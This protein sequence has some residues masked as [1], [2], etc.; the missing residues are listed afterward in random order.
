V[1]LPP[2]RVL[3][4]CLVSGICSG[5][6]GFV[7]PNS[8]ILAFFLPGIFYGL[9]FLIWLPSGKKSRLLTQ[10]T[11]VLASGAICYAAIRLAISAHNSW[12]EWFGFFSA[13]Y[14]GAALLH[15]L[16]GF[17]GQ[18]KLSLE[19]NLLAAFSG[20]LLGLAFLFQVHPK[21]DLNEAISLSLQFALWQVGMGIVLY[22][23]ALEETAT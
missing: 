23:Q 12:P 6:V 22:H 8:G 4:L 3:L 5:L 19:K 21:S 11:L 16:L 7:L 18:L 20:A 14:F 15:L 9:L 17:F 1:K 2:L 13:G 10:G